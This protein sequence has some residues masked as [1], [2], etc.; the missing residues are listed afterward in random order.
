MTSMD[1]VTIARS[2][3]VLAVLHWMGGVAFVTTV[4]LPAVSVMPQSSLRL[5]LFEA[6]EHRFSPQVKASVPL[7]GASGAYMTERLDFEHHVPRE[8]SR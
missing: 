2:V 4:I 1:D 5:Q 6:I 3:R 7:A 8:G